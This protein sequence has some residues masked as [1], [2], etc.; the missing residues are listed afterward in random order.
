M[1]SFKSPPASPARKRL[2]N[3]PQSTSPKPQIYDITGVIVCVGEVQ[4]G[5]RGNSYFD[6]KLKK[7]ENT[8]ENVKV[9][10]LGVKHEQFCKLIGRPVVL[11]KVSSS[12]RTIFFNAQ[13][14]SIIE[15]KKY[16]LEFSNEMHITKIKDIDPSSS[17]QMHFCGIIYW[18]GK[19]NTTTD[20]KTLREGVIHDETGEHR[21]TVWKESLIN[22]IE[23]QSQYIITDCQLRYY[24]KLIKL[25]TT[26]NT[27]VQQSSLEMDLEPPSMIEDDPEHIII[28]CPE[29]LTIEIKREKICV[30]CKMPIVVEENQRHLRCNN[31]QK[32][33]LVKRLGE[34]CGGEIQ[35]HK[36]DQDFTATFD[37]SVFKSY[38]TKEV[39]EDDME[40]EILELNNVDFTLDKVTNDLV[41]ISEHKKDNMDCTN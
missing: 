39:D 10:T 32:L 20:G 18:A 14:N 6:L 2:F 22:T 21:I 40:I 13:R 4:M 31:C 26:W 25:T 16:E 1:A 33:M 17:E 7:S 9:M 15:E 8:M 28:C 37:I 24:N 12:D 23:H 36:G 19:L 41:H 27:V 5:S 11:K 3:S 35:L 30:N 38:F 34:R 29:I